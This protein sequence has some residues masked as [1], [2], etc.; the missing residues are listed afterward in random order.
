MRI[1]KR[2]ID[3][4]KSLCFILQGTGFSII[5]LLLSRSFY[6]RRKCILKAIEVELNL[7]KNVL[8]F[9]STYHLRQH[10]RIIL[11]T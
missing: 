6:L 5:Q 10:K 3:E 7:E 8:K 9:K 11:N 4:N 2:N 1:F